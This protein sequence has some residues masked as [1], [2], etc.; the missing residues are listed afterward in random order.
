MK[1]RRESDWGY[2]DISKAETGWIVKMTSRI[3]GDTTMETR[4][5]P[6]ETFPELRTKDLKDDSSPYGNHQSVADFVIAAATQ[7][8]F[9]ITR[10]KGFKV[11]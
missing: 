4:L 7:N 8:G 1:L 10:K 5:I 2:V 6:Y 3:I 11:C 9:Y